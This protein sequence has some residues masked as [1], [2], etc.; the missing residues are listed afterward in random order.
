[1][2][3]GLIAVLIAGCGLAEDLIGG[4]TEEIDGLDQ[5]TEAVDDPF[6]G[7][8]PTAT[9]PGD[10]AVEPGQPPTAADRQAPCTD[11]DTQL[12]P[13]LPDIAERVQQATAD[14]T[15]DGQADQVITYAIITDQATTFMIRMVTASGYVVEASLDEAVEM[16]PVQPLGGAAI[17]SDR[18]VV[19]V[20]E[21]SGAAGPNVSLW[22]LHELDDHPCA[23]M[24]VTVPDHTAGVSFPV[25]GTIGSSS[26][27]FCDDL[28]D[29]GNQELVVRTAEQQPDGGYEVA[30]T[31]W[32]WPGHGELQLVTDQVFAV[33]DQAD[34]DGLLD[35][36]CPGVTLP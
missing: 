3:L 36:G 33:A 23:L 7:D 22:A 34:L 27:L 28:N 30:S 9:E 10:P 29:D 17:G 19:L 18:E 11:A 21:S 26:T 31:G 4:L 14:V 2:V 1:M 25:R 15:G 16:A 6:G 5:L 24:R 8:E 32:N 20:I 12:D 35:F 13:E